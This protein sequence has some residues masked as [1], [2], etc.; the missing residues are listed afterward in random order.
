MRPLLLLLSASLL[1]PAV[2]AGAQ[3]MAY[4]PPDSAPISSVQVTARPTVQRIKT[5]EAHKISG[6]YDMSNGWNLRVHP[7]PRHIDT[8][9][10]DQPPLRLNAV[11]PYKFVSG[12]GN[13]TMQ[14]N[15][16]DDGDMMEMSYRPDLHLAE[17]IVISSRVAQR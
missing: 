5:S 17:R 6:A 15:R 4:P 12:D 3:A 8:I 10:D 14:F 11:A 2:N 16:G 1:L 9:I 7:G 13:V